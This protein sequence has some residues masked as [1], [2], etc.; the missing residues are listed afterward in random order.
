MQ[1]ATKTQ[2]VIW[3][4]A[5]GLS[6]CS[7]ASGNASPTTT[8]STVPPTTT[9]T[10]I[11]DRPLGVSQ[12]TQA[13]PSAMDLPTGWTATG[14]GDS[15][16][17]ETLKP[18]TGEGFGF[19]S[20]PNFDE[21]L[22]RSGVVAWAWSPLLKPSTGGEYG[23]IGVFEFPNSASASSY[24]DLV[25]I[26]KA[27]GSETYKARELGEGKT[28]EDTPDEYRTNQFSGSDNSTMWSVSASYS[29]GA[30]LPSSRAPGLTALNT[31]EYS[32]RRSGQNYGSIDQQVVAY[33]R[34]QNV[35]LR[36]MI[37]GGC[38]V[39]GFSNTE[40]NSDDSRPSMTT[41]DEFASK[42]RDGILVSLGLDKVYE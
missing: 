13:I 41:L 20:G 32:T 4:V 15:S 27:C 21:M 34:Y 30:P 40:T 19:C 39:Y 31:W 38:C 2:A 16:L 25:S 42:V 35:V 17:T 12:L 3:T 37:R 6:A 7:S 26:S 14:S 33:E 22:K 23:Y 24:I 11:V 1:F 8:P 5:I 36:F 9:T 18:K 29:V 10:T 28:Q